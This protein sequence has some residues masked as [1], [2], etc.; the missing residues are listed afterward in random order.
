M[1]NESLIATATFIF[2]QTI[3][4]SKFQTG[5]KKIEWQLYKKSIQISMMIFD[6]HIISYS[7]FVYFF[8]LPLCI[9]NENLV[10]SIVSQK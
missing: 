7:H 10:A 3:L 2:E 4:S 8:T 1:S 5:E 9:Y 6:V